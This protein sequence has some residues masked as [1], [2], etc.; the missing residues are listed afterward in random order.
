MNIV[1]K[2]SGEE[3]DEFVSSVPRQ[4]IYCVEDK[5]FQSAPAG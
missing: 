3:V 2:M 1:A 4:E 5:G